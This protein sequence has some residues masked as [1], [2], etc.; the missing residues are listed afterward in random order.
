ME[1][2]LPL[3]NFGVFLVY[4]SIIFSGWRVVLCEARAELN[5]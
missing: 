5:Q 3:F 2:F 1:R 4:S